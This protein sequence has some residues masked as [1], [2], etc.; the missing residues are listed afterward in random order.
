MTFWM[1]D[2]ELRVDAAGLVAGAGPRVG[3]DHVALAVR[4]GELPGARELALGAITNDIV[5]HRRMGVSQASSLSLG[6]KLGGY[7]LR[8][9]IDVS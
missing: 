6:R 4:L 1:V 8:L 2:V 3:P 9:T 7:A 5:K